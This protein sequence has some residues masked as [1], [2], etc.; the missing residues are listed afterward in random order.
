MTSLGFDGLMPNS[1]PRETEAATDGPL[2]RR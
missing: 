1:V 2:D